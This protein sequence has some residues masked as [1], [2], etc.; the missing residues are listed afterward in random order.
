VLLI[1]FAVYVLLALLVMFFQRRLIYFPTKLTVK[2]AESVAATEGFQPW[3]N[4]T[5]Q[6]IGW[7][8]PSKSPTTG[9][10]LIVHGNAGCAVDRGYLAKPIHEAGNGSTDV[11]VL[12]YPGYGGRDGSPS[13][14]S[15]LSAAQEAF[16]LLTNRVPIYVVSESIGAGVAA[17]LAQKHGGQ[18]AGLMLLVPYNDLVSVAQRQ[19]P[20]LPVSLLL[21]DRY[22]PAEWL[23]DYR[24]PVAMVLAGA[25]NVI[26]PE[27]GRRLHD[28]YA[29]PK[30]FEIVPGAGHN[31]VASQS[32]AWWRE[33]FAFWHRHQSSLNPAK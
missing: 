14:Q 25:D 6:I 23:K 22:N 16:A 21:W 20:F 12:E 3:R 4:S 17:H 32:P 7:R 26:P 13:Q 1:L 28:T 15:I 18:I 9:V 11:C 24:G 5:G 2:L 31:D 8:M 33:T 30:H 10:V 29:G 27:F 19:M